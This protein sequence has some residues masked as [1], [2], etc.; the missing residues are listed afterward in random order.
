MAPR[1]YHTGRVAVTTAGK[2]HPLSGTAL[3]VRSLTVQSEVGNTGLVHLGGPT[4][5]DVNYNVAALMG[6]VLVPGGADQPGGSRTFEI[7]EG[8]TLDIST[9]FVDAAVNG[10]GVTF[11]YTV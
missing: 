6:I 1:V 3:R 8:D 11:D 7:D 2:P 5:N 9:V 10:D 4:E